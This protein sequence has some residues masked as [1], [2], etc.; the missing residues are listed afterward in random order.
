MI[1]I[2]KN[3]SN[4]VLKKS[5]SLFSNKYKLEI[6]YYLHI[7]GKMR[8][9]EIK[10]EIGTITQ[11]LLTKLLRG[12]EKNTLITREESKDFPRR[13]DYS[14]TNFGKSTKAMINSIFKWEQNNSRL[15]NKV[16]KK[17]IIDSIYDYY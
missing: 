6:I 7:R 16:I 4:K 8:F 1:D 9:G 11:Q 5:L 10:N 3:I 14:L 12:M 2:E 17:N 13:V 15:I